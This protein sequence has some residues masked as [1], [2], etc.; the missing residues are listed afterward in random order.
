MA[1]LST[2][3]FFP[4]ALMVGILAA[5]Y[6]IV[7]MKLNLILWVPFISWA[8]FFI[9][10]SK[11]SRLPKEI[12]GLTGGLVFAALLLWLLPTF[13]NL[14]GANWGLPILVF[15]V[16]FLIV[17]LEVTNWFELAPAYFFSF[18]GFFALLF[19]GSVP[20]QMTWGNIFTFW[21]L[22]MIGLGLGVITSFLRSRIL[23]L[24]KVPLEER[25]TIFDKEK[26]II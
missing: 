12:I 22:L 19:G 18:A 8:L 17:M 6:I 23:D 5:L 20:A 3:K 4:V 1:Q 13:I 25:Q 15:L 26:R 24:L 2:K 14:F 11:Y 7:G 16:A 9:A 10:G 21:Y